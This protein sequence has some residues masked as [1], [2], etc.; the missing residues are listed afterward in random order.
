M[1]KVDEKILLF[2]REKELIKAGDKILIALSGGADS[3]FALRFLHQKKDK[4]KI[5]FAAA[6][7]NHSLRGEASDKDEI[8]CEVLCNRLGI[9]FYSKKLDV[10][11]FAREKKL[12]IEEAA[13]DM[14]YFYLKKMASKMKCSKILT[15]HNLN[16]NS[17]TVLYNL[18]KGT[19]LAGLSGIPP[20]RENIIR[21]FL[22]VSKNEILE[23][24]EKLNQDFRTDKSNYSNKF[25]RNFIRNEIIPK[26][27]TINPSLHQTFFS[28][29][30]IF[31]ES[32]V[33]IRKHLKDVIEK[34]VEDYE[35]S[36]KIKNTILD[37]EG[38]SLGAILKYILKDKFSYTLNF[39]NYS[40]IKNLFNLQTGKEIDLGRELSAFKERG[41]VLIKKKTKL[42]KNN[43]IRIRIGET[44]KL[45]NSIFGIEETKNEKIS[46]EN[47]EFEIIS[48]ENLDD[49]FILRRWNFGDKFIPL[50]MKGIK[51]VSDFLNEQKIPAHKKKE[52]YVLINRNN[53]VWVVG[54]RIDDRFKITETTESKIK[55]WIK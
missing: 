45:E 48:A 10:E 11:E 38:E 20:K 42:E 52:Q 7:I 21:P 8:F 5:N 53:I 15:A 12:S 1:K 39:E 33:I 51:K 34:Y 14:R 32:E 17:E 41:F 30:R 43:E 27:E 26:L 16:D 55:L 31:E 35:L 18:V 3:V 28:A 2:I 50:G 19:G 47:K 54:L 44:I 40:K 22:T 9:E 49:I 23:Y 29:S 25:Q 36:I 6:H 13:R 4:L 46:G 24:L 37:E